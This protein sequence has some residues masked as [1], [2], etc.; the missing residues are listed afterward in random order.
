MHQ[1]TS[2]NQWSIDVPQRLLDRALGEDRL[3]PDRKLHFSQGCGVTHPGI[4]HQAKYSSC[5]QR[6]RQ[7]IPEVAILTRA[8]GSHYK[9]V[10]SLTLLDRHMNHPIVSRGHLT[11]DGC[12]HNLGRTVDR[13]QVG[14]QQTLATLCFVNCGNVQLLIGLHQCFRWTRNVCDD[15]GHQNILQQMKN[16][17][18]RDPSS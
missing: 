15:N 1:R 2:T 9:D 6:V 18:E 11:G 14:R 17:K 3:G 4:N 8:R 10:S 7:Q 16:S 13:A 12:A 5:L